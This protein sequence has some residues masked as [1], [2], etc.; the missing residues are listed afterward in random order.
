MNHSNIFK[1]LFFILIIISNSCT[2]P[3]IAFDEI[4]YENDFENDLS[5]DIDGYKTSLYNNSNVLGN[6]NNDGF[7]LHL[8]N[9][10]DHDYVFISFD[11]YI[12]GSWD[13][14]S[15]GFSENDRPDKW[16]LNLK[17]NMDI[18]Q[19]GSLDSFTTTFSNT[20]CFSNYCFLQSYP[21]SF[22]FNNIPKT[23]SSAT[24]LNEFC[25]NSFFGGNTT[26]YKFEKGFTHSGNAL[27][28]SI[29]DE[30]YQPN[31]IDNNGSN[32]QICDES[33]SIDNL[34]IRIINYE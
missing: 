34:K 8:N 18:Y 22:P 3:K 31:A 20:P 2:Y 25:K 30:L 23:G 4:V 12:H 24:E 21:N 1:N 9:I 19:T 33:W 6:F 13:G 17:P 15:N 16:I 27:I 28:L 10:K 11:L 14:N 32:Q 7:I 29:F 5:K 26:L